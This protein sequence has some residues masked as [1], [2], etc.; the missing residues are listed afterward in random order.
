MK[1]VGG[2]G[3][4]TKC[5]LDFNNENNRV[6]L[7]FLNTAFSFK[8]NLEKK[9][10]P[11]ILIGV[12]DSLLVISLLLFKILQIRP[13]TIHYT[14]SA[15][16]ALIK[17]YFAIYI[18]KIFGIKFIIHWHF[19]RIPEILK[20]KNTEWKIFKTV[21]KAADVSVVLDQ[22]SLRDLN[23][24]GITNVV[25]IPNPIS[26]HLCR[27]AESVN[28]NEKVIETGTF[29]FVGHIIPAKGVFELVEA[30]TRIE[31]VKQLA[32]IGPVSESVKHSLISI[33]SKRNNGEWLKWTGEIH[34]EEVLEYLKS[35]NAL[36]LPSYTEGFPNAILEAMAMGCP[37]I[38][39]KVGAIEEM[40][41]SND[42]GKAG[43]C[44]EPRNIAQ[45]ILAIQF[46]ITNSEQVREYGR[47]GNQRVLSKF[48]LEHVFH[49][50]ECLW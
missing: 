20:A 25:E 28:F 3:T 35:A 24:L 48:S 15:S 4:W 34:R 10:L 11:R 46:T 41:A 23:N 13:K 29:I 22:N 9:T 50:Y 33:A 17:D 2:I 21:I 39:T 43:I 49:Q 40:V 6:D 44:I 31:S 7:A 19:G 8:T 5:I 26:E 47:N 42:F 27:I 32:L 37:V 12:L 14:S 38:A 18:A 16:F 36:C 1:K 30:C 45:L